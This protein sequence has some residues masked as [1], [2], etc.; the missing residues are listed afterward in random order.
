MIS[1]NRIEWVEIDLA[2]MTI[3][4]ITVPSFVTNNAKDNIYI[5]K[6]C[7]PKLVIFENYKT[8]ITNKKKYL[9]FFQKK[10]LF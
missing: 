3:G 1:S 8:L 7:D 5:I 4:A 2:I 9:N 6:N 10:K